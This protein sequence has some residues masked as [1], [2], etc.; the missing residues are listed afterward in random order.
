MILIYPQMYKRADRLW[1][2][3]SPSPRT[4][5]CSLTSLTT[6]APLPHFPSTSRSAARQSHVWASK[7]GSCAAPWGGRRVNSRQA[8]KAVRRL[9]HLHEE[10]LRGPPAAAIPSWSSVPAGLG[11]G[12]GVHNGLVLVPPPRG[13]PFLPTPLRGHPSAVSSLPHIYPF[14]F[15]SSPS[16][17]VV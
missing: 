6:G 9:V 10:P 13:P 5:V 3:P 17:T 15:T 14:P 16:A 8:I 12:T 4:D 11:G 2:T 7:S 1:K